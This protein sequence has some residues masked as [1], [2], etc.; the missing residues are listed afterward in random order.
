[1]TTI[2]IIGTI[3]LFISFMNN[4]CNYFSDEN[5]LTANVEEWEKKRKLK[6]YRNKLKKNN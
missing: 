6:E 3:I 4:M 2:C 1:M 5:K